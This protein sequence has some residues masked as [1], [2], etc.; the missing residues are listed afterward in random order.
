MVITMAKL[1]MAHT[2]AHGERKPP[3]PIFFLKGKQKFFKNAMFWTIACIMQYLGQTEVDKFVEDGG[4]DRPI[5]LILKLDLSWALIIL[6][7]QMGVV[8]WRQRYKPPVN[9]YRSE[10][11][12]LEHLII[13]FGL[14]VVGAATA[15]VVFICEIGLAMCK[16]RY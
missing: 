7:V 16:Y 13:P 14:L 5:M 12:K 8:F 1:R 6:L 2:S 4:G 15:L 10:K 11:I 3:G 9:D